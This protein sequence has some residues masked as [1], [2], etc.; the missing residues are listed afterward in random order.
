[1]EAAG[2]ACLQVE[3]RAVTLQIVPRWTDNLPGLV[4]VSEAL[5]SILAN[6]D[7]TTSAKAAIEERRHQPHMDCPCIDCHRAFGTVP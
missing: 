2:R 6:P 4:H 7:I 3:T 5:R 1:V